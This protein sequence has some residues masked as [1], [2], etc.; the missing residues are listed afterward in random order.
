VS[1]LREEKK[2]QTRTAIADAASMLF[3]ERGFHRVTV[4]EVAHAARVS[5]Q[6][7]FNHFPAKEDLVFDRAGEIQAMMV[8]AIRDREPGTS[9]V[10]AFRAMTHGFWERLAEAPPDRPQS[11]FFQIVHET[12]S[13]Q[14]YARELGAR[15]VDEL[16][17]V[18]AEETGAA[19]GDARPRVLATAL[20]TAHQTVLDA[21]RAR[22]VA[23]EQP[24]ALAAEALARA[25]EAYDLLGRLRI[26]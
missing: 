19:P 18:I 25:D 15:T 5:K 7:V 8:A 16:T 10:A 2:R 22:I 14:A 3:E 1:T 6:T 11:G 12:P 20:V 24:A 17:S 23:G 4:D 21:A 26:A 9:L 13:L